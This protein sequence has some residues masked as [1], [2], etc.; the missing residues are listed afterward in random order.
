[1][2]RENTLSFACY[3]TWRHEQDFFKPDI[4]KIANIPE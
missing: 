2:L 4:R 1:M 3:L